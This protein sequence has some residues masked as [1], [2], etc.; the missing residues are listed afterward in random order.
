MAFN[1]IQIYIIF[2]LSL[3]GLCPDI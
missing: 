3:A 2:V 1:Q